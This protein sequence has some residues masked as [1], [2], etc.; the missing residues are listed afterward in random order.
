VLWRRVQLLRRREGRGGSAIR[1]Q[2]QERPN[3]AV[4]KL[5]RRESGTAPWW[6]AASFD[7]L[8]DRGS[9][10]AATHAGSL[11]Y[12]ERSPSVPEPY[13][14]SPIDSI[15][16]HYGTEIDACQGLLDFAV[17]E[18]QA[19]SG[20]P[21]KQGADRIILAE[22]A[23]ATKTLH[24]VIVLCVDGF[25]EQAAMLNRSMFEGMAVAHWVSEN[26]REAVGRFTRH[27]KFNAVL[28]WETLEVLGW[29]DDESPRQR[30]RVG[31]KLR[32][33]YVDEFGKYGV[34]SWFGGN[35][36]DLLGKIEHLWDDQG[37]ADLWAFHNV[38]HR[39]SNQILHSTTTALGATYTGQTATE[40]SLSIGPSNQLV[41]QPLLAAYWIYGQVFSLVITDF[42]LKCGPSY[43]AVF[44]AG[45][46]SFSTASE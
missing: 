46:K 38:A 26:R 13:D 19:W 25:G 41:Q 42:R 20:R 45:W 24:A 15:R 7:R 21:A 10:Q 12:R 18:L 43:R 8:Q 39:H 11:A 35:L 29:L 37:R 34:R 27:H 31:P 40:L 17:A 28:W 33:A 30:P 5:C 22:A 14:D 2:A 32:K 4:A 36:P 1:R 44:D 23:R 16:D 9:R 3:H 6:E